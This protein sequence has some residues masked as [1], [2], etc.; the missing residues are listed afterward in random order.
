MDKF[1][2]TFKELQH[3]VSLT[4]VSG[5]WKIEENKKLFRANNGA[6]L[7]WWESTKTISFQ[8]TEDIKEQFKEK[9]YSVDLTN[10]QPP[11]TPSTS[12][13]TQEQ[14][15][16]I[17]HGND[18]HAEHLKLI[19]QNLGLDPYIVQNKDIHSLA[20]IEALELQIYQTAFG[21]ILMTPDEYGSPQNLTDTGG[22][23]HAKQNVILEMGMVMASVGRERMVIL[24]KGNLEMPSGVD[25]I[26]CLEFNQ[27]IKEI[28]D[29]LVQSIKKAGIKIVDKNL[30]AER[31]VEDEPPW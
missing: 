23:P 26:N 29:K 4:G 25:G 30:N 12:T 13:L 1:N 27:Q 3:R 16:V 19:L 6:I 8:G 20:V 18:E 31:Q 7:S 2:G 22:M 21:I 10:P 28:E 9:F 5:E 24:K 15:L 11:S 14:K 17:V